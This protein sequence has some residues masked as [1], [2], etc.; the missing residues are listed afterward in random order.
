MVYKKAAEQ[1]DAE[2]Q[3]ELGKCYDIFCAFNKLYIKKNEEKALEWYKKARDQGYSEAQYRYGNA[4]RHYSGNSDIG[5]RYRI[6][7]AWIKKAA[8]NKNP[9]IEAC[10]D[11]ADGHYAMMDEHGERR[12]KALVG[13]SLLAGLG[14]VV[15][16]PVALAENAVI[17][18]VK[19]E[20]FLKTTDEGKEMMKYYRKAAALGSE[21]AKKRIKEIENY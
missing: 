14:A 7:E 21:K 5:A 3:C 12:K 1:G 16:V 19:V 13:S 2:A 20:K 15:T 4:Y 11:I 18:S 9:C 17:K 8:D 10:L 6:A